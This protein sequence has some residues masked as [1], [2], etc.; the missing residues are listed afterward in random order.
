MGRIDLK[1]P[2]VILHIFFEFLRDFRLPTRVSRVNSWVE[3]YQSTPRAIFHIYDDF[4]K[5]IARMYASYKGELMGRIGQNHLQ[6]HTTH[7]C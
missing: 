7:L 6:N 5:R 4:G 2:K 1:H 3:L